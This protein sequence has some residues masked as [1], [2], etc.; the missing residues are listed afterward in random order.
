VVWYLAHVRRL[1]PWSSDVNDTVLI[2]PPAQARPG[3]AE[4]RRLYETIAAGASKRD[5]ERIH[6]HHVLSLL[7]TVRFAALS[8]P[9]AQGGGGA[10]LRD[11]I[12]E[13]ILLAEADTNVAHIFR[14]HFMFVE[15]F[16]AKS[17]ADRHPAWRRTVLDGGIVGLGTTELNRPVTGGA[18]PMKTTLAPDG[19]GWRLRGTKYYSTGTLYADLV[20]IK[21]TAPGDVGVTVI[22]PTD[23]DGVELVDDWDGIGQR[24]TGTGTTNLHDVRVEAHEVDIDRDNPPGLLPYIST[25]AQLFVTAIVA[26]T[27]R[28]SLRDAKALLL[29]RGRNFY[30]APSS[31]ASQDPILQQ[32]IGQLS[33]N[34]FAAEHVVLAAAERLA[35]AESARRDGGRFEELA[36][37][38]AVAAAKAKVIADELALRSATALFDVGGAS[39]ATQ[40]QNLDRHWRNARTLSTHN[41]ASYKAQALG[42]WEVLGT[43]LPGLGFF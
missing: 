28:A 31:V 9:V 7:R 6:P 30:F 23:R 36:H 3:S 41:P 20:L 2:D 43:R 18:V 15:R 27:A 40:R 37:E 33:A 22:I 16:L 35:T 29:S 19:D 21:A 38:A 17:P 8:L 11:V 26:G 25:I 1:Q 4:L 10:S 12:A 34:A 24:V 13:A 39:A 5:A 32:A 14:N 42:A